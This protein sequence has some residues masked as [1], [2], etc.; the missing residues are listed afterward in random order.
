MIL[1]GLLLI[2]LAWWIWR[3]CS[4]PAA[5]A[6][7]KEIVETMEKEAPAVAVE[8][9][10]IKAAAAGTAPPVAE[11]AAEVGSVPA[12][13]E[14]AS[15]RTSVIATFDDDKPSLVVTTPTTIGTFGT[16]RPMRGA[17]L[18]SM[19][20]IPAGATM[21]AA[22][23]LAGTSNNYGSRPLSTASLGSTAIDPQASRPPTMVLDDDALLGS[24]APRSRT[25]Y[26]STTSRSAAPID[27]ATAAAVA[28]GARPRSMFAPG[29][30]PTSR[31]RPTTGVWD[32]AGHFSAAPKDFAPAN[33]API[34]VGPDGAY[35]V[36]GANGMEKLTPPPGFYPAPLVVMQPNGGV[37]YDPS[38]VGNRSSMVSVGSKRNS[39]AYRGSMLVEPGMEAGP[40]TAGA[41]GSATASS[42]SSSVPTGAPATP[43]AT[44]SANAETK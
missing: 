29:P 22:A 27:P 13:V 35:Y 12:I 24:V 16:E 9:S 23:T 41:G 17:E 18:D 14:P 1:G 43:A 30:M 7:A 4:Q 26:A 44:P 2:G 37:G 21:A 5:A 8:V 40:S 11:K 36:A 15:N 19:N 34:F 33:G 25:S 3:K 28:A 6:P 38:I 31:D 42:S 20:S 10:D 39:K 32:G